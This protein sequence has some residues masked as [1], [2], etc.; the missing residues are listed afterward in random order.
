MGQSASVTAQD[1]PS[2]SCNS[3]PAQHAPAQ[4]LEDFK[5]SM[6]NFADCPRAA[7]TKGNQDWYIPS[8]PDLDNFDVCP[9]CYDT[10][11]AQLLLPRFSAGVRPSQLM[12]RIAVTS[13]SCG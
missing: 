9:T 4:S 6:P 10:S 2:T 13:R 1:A 7:Y 8:S 12:W 5:S 3:P 11:I